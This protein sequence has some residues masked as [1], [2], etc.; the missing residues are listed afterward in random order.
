MSLQDKKK[1]KLTRGNIRI[2]SFDATV[3]PVLF[4]HNNFLLDILNEMSDRIM[5]SPKRKIFE[6]GNSIEY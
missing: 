1:I 4:T 2:S 5:C 6:D 3:V